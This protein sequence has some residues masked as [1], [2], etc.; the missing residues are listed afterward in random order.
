MAGAVANF[1]LGCLSNFQ[2]TAPTVSQLIR[3][4]QEV[5]SEYYLRPQCVRKSKN[6]Q[7]KKKV[8]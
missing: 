1:H 6:L 5:Q 8:I 4:C 3:K 7:I 2:A